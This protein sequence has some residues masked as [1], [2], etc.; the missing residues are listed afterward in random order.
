[1]EAFICFCS[2]S[3]DV[4]M[5]KFNRYLFCGFLLSCGLP[6]FFPLLI[7]VTTNNPFWRQ[8]W[9]R[10]NTRLKSRWQED[11]RVW[12]QEH[13]QDE[14]QKT[15]GRKESCWVCGWVELPAQK[16]EDLAPHLPSTLLPKHLHVWLTRLS[17][18]IPITHWL[19]S[20]TLV[21]TARG[22]LEVRGALDQA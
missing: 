17:A 13:G 21:C 20:P 4:L 1:M 11:T 18:H 16:D 5:R 8:Q 14:R 19:F 15:Q 2:G 12:R 22:D 10:W 6:L 7:E 3:K 9:H